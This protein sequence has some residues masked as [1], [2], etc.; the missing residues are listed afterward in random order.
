M[1]KD[2]HILNSEWTREQKGV[3]IRDVPPDV[4]T[5]MEIAE[6]KTYGNDRRCP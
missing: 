1:E 5:W 6:F 3:G 2:A 4:L